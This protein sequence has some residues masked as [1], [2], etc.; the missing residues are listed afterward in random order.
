MRHAVLPLLVTLGWAIADGP[1]PWEEGA[2]GRVATACELVPSAQLNASSPCEAGWERPVPTRE[3]GAGALGTC[4]AAN[5]S[6]PGTPHQLTREFCVPSV[7]LLGP[8]KTGTT[9]LFYKLVQARERARETFAPSLAPFRTLPSLTT[10]LA[11]STQRSPRRRR[12]RARPARSRPGGR[13]S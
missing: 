8:E 11:R 9:A 4:Y 6:L 3:R 2:W 7:W 13:A 10:K 5:A 12:T 1:Q